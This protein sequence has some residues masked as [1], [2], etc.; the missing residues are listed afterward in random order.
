MNVNAWNVKSLQQLGD[1]QTKGT[2]MTA[3]ERGTGSKQGNMT[4]QCYGNRV[5]MTSWYIS[6]YWYI[7]SISDLLRCRNKLLTASTSPVQPHIW[8]PYLTVFVVFTAIKVRSVRVLMWQVSWCLLLFCSVWRPLCV[9]ARGML[10]GRR[11]EVWTQWAAR[12]NGS[13]WPPLNSP[14][15]KNTLSVSKRGALC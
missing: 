11:D 7:Y 6:M 3:A 15:Y 13:H 5:K 12:T 1:R 8:C 4:C 9:A 10:G 2:D 14:C